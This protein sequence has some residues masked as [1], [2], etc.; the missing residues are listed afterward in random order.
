MREN[1]RLRED[2][3]PIR[4]S[5]ESDL[6]EY[7]FS[8]LDA[9][10][11][12]RRL[13]R[14]HTLLRSAFRT[15]GRA[16]E[17]IVRHGDPVDPR[18]GFHRVAAACAYHL[19]GYAAI[20]FALF[21]AVDSQEQNLNTAERCLVQLLH[22]NLD[23]LL[24][25]AEAWLTEDTNQDAILAAQLQSEDPDFDEALSSILNS[26]VCR[27][28]ANF[29]FALRT[30]EAQFI[31]NSA[32]LLAAAFNVAQDRGFVSLWW[33][34][35]LTQ[36]L[37]DDLWSHSLHQVIPLAPQSDEAPLYSDYRRT[38]I[39]SLF[40]L[41]TSQVELWPSQIDAA[42]RAA[43]PQDDLVV[44]LPT[45]AGKTRIAEL[46]AL[47]TLSAG[48]RVLI[49]TPLRALSAQT[50]RSFRNAFSPVGASVSSLYGASGLSAGDA[51]A[52]RSSQIVVSTPEK[53]DFAL[54][55]DPN[56][57]DDIGLIV[58]D[59]GHLIGPGEREIRSSKTSRC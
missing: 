38:F 58:L 33:V 40:T 11:E 18:R 44:A 26:G 57:I 24:E 20:A 2:A 39:A 35:R 31:E 32:G 5:I 28:F 30:G 4:Q 52:L 50:E 48:K 36:N 25:I 51:D 3:P 16:F 47:T 14:S 9:A 41:S 54:R 21:Q 27:A 43:D 7:A 42:R 34:I 10:L 45:S 55:S 23:G 15:A 13:E 6:S 19:G 46:A 1:G 53:L 37:L 49:V 8:V 17:A 22:R 56:V 12:L 59:E 29:E